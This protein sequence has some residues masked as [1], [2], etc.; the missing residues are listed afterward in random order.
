M[1]AAEK[2][3]ASCLRVLIGQGADTKA[4]DKVSNSYY[5]ITTIACIYNVRRQNLLI[6]LGWQ[7]SNDTCC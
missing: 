2:G 7:D 5:N 3:S 4:T 6:S 1:H